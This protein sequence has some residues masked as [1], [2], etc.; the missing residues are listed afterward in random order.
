MSTPQR[1]QK[2]LASHGLCSRRHAEDLITSGQVQ[3]NGT[4][5]TQLGTCI[6]PDVDC[7]T[8]AGQP[9]KPTTLRYY[10]INKPQG[11][12]STCSDPFGRPTVLTLLP[13]AERQG[14]HPV[15]RLDQDT[16]GALILTNDGALTQKLTHPSHQLWKM[17]HVQVS[18]QPPA[19]ILKQWRA[20][21]LLEGR[22]TLPA[23]IRIL[24]TLAAS[25]WL[26]VQLTEGRNRQIRRVA[27]ILNFPVESLRRVAIGSLRLGDLPL[28]S[29]RHLTVAQVQALSTES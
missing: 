15:G 12:L 29:Y 4:I 24:K 27:Q 7:V 8:V 6:D 20:G 25:T 11:L 9:L 16:E 26:E 13:E 5:V 28:G 3:V 1:L 23:R 22:L 10:L 14:L 18:G 2:H 17:Y 19:A 21:V